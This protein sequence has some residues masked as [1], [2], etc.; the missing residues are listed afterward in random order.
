MKIELSWLQDVAFVADNGRAA[1][2]I[3]DG[4]PQYGGKDLGM[5]PMEGMLSAAAACGA[6]DVVHILKKSRQSLK[7][8]HIT[9]K[10]ERADEIPSV[11]TRINL[12]FTLAGE[13]SEVVVKRAI[14]LS[15]EKYCSALA[16]LNKTATV[17][18]S[19]EI[20]SA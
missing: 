11:F 1:K 5:R 18:H 13:L 14:S 7:S 2:I 9:I 15:V 17:E 6:F 12:H 4:P 8:L 16:M 19:W 20:I 3:F 10:A